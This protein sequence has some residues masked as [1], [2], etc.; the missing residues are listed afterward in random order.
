MHLTNQKCLVMNKKYISVNVVLRLAL[1]G[2]FDN[3]R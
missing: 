3:L 2:R 1:C